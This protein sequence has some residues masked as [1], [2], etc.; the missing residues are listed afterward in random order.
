MSTKWGNE[1]DSNI[2][3]KTRQ[4]PPTTSLLRA[5]LVTFSKSKV[6]SDIWKG[7]AWKGGVTHSVSARWGEGSK[8]CGFQARCEEEFWK[9]QSWTRTGWVLECFS[10]DGAGPAWDNARES[11]VQSTGLCKLVG[12]L[13]FQVRGSTGLLKCTTHSSP[14]YLDFQSGSI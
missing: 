11:P 7:T 1:L 3:T 4:F 14:V 5:E 9:I 12:I 8:R 2:E 6:I 10:R 13:L